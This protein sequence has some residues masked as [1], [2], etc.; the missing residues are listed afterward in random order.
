MKFERNKEIYSHK[1]LLFNIFRQSAARDE[2]PASGRRS[3][4]MRTKSP[5]IQISRGTE[6]RLETV[7]N[8]V[9]FSE[10]G[11]L[12]ETTECVVLVS[13]VVEAGAFLERSQSD[14]MTSAGSEYRSYEYVVAALSAECL[15]KISSYLLNLIYS[16]RVDG[17]TAASRG[18][19]PRRDSR[20]KDQAHTSFGKVRAVLVSLFL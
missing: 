18:A 19:W 4:M 15:F 12:R 6:G 17:F 5:Q 3:K 14:I 7:L 11:F 2:Q 9:K 20:F 1:V 10:P 13:N 8:K 16:L